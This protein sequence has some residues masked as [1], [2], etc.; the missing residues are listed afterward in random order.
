MRHQE[1]IKNNIELHTKVELEQGKLKFM[2]LVKKVINI[3]QI[4]NAALIVLTDIVNTS[5]NE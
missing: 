1:Q 3:K 5:I 2:D 4:G